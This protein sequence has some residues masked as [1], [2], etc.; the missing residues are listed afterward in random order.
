MAFKVTYTEY[1]DSEH[2][3]DD[4]YEVLESGVLKVTSASDEKIRYF[5]MDLWKSLIADGDHEEGHPKSGGH[6]MVM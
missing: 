6:P 5:V 4:T 3:D 2:S 1:P